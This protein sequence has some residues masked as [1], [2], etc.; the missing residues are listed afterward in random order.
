MRILVLYAHP[1]GTSFVAA[2]CI[3]LRFA[4]IRGGPWLRL[5]QGP[6]AFELEVCGSEKRLSSSRKSGEHH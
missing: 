3:R 5:R 6:S 4:R 2:L 1:V